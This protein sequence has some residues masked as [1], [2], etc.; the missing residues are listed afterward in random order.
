MA[1][2]NNFHTGDPHHGPSIPLQDLGTLDN[3]REGDT[4]RRSRSGHTNGSRTGRGARF[5]SLRGPTGGRYER[6]A[7]D[8]PSRWEHDG[9]DTVDLS[10]GGISV[11]PEG[12]DDYAIGPGLAH[13]TVGLSFDPDARRSSR[14]GPQEN[15]EGRWDV[16]EDLGTYSNSE[17]RPSNELERYCSP[18][19]TGENDRTP[20]TDQRYLQPI[21]GATAPEGRQSDQRSNQSV[22]FAN[23]VTAGSHLGDDL[24]HLEE[25]LGREGDGSQSDSGRS[26]LS[27]SA[28]IS[29]AGSVMRMISQRVVN[30]SNEPEM[31]EQPTRRKSSIRNARM[32]GPPSLPAMTEYAHDATERDK[33]EDEGTN[34]IPPLFSKNPPA[35]S[36]P[37]RGKSLG[38][39]SPENKL[40][41]ALCEILIHPVTEPLIFFLIILHTVLLAIESEF[42]Q[43]PGR[44]QWGSPWFDYA[45]LAL[46]II[47]TFELAAKIIVS[48]FIINP[49]EYSTLDRSRGLR[50]ALIDKGRSLFM[51]YRKKSIKKKNTKPE[52][53]SILRTFTGFPQEPDRA[54]DWA[55]QA[56]V[57][58]ARRAFLRHSFN[59]LDF[60]AVV[61]YWISFMLSI[62]HLESK[63]HLYVF[64]ML[65]CLR[66]LRLM[67]LTEGTLLILKGLKKAA[68]LLVNVAFF[69]CFFWLLFAIIGVQS[70]KSSLRRTCVWIDPD[71]VSNFT[72]NQAPD[73]LQL[74]GGYLES[75]T[76]VQK[77]WL[78]PDG[79]NGS[80]KPKGFLC[81]QG[82][83]CIE[84]V[85]PYSGTMSFDN[86]IQSLELVFVIMS[87][88]T[89]TDLLYY[90]TDSD[91]MA[92]ASFFIVGFV[93]LSLWLVNLLIAVITS[94]FQVIR[95]ERKTQSAFTSKKADRVG[96]E[97]TVLRKVS[98]LKR[99]YDK[100]YSFWLVII[101]FGLVVQ[102][103]RSSS[104]GPSRTKFI[105][106]TELAV[107]IIL[108]VEI[109]LR[110]FSDFR[111]FFR[112]AQNWVDL[113]LAITTTIIQLPPIKNSG[114][115][116]DAL[117][118]FQILRI[119][120]VVLS[121][122]LTRKLIMTVFR[123]VVGLLNLVFF[124]AIITLIT[125]IFAIQ[126]FRNQMPPEN[127]GEVTRVG[128]YNIWNAFIGM[129][130]VLSSENWTEILYSATESGT[131][132][133]TAWIAATF[134]I[135]WF[136][137]ANLIVLNMFIA[138]IQESF[139]V[140]EDEK[141]L[142]QVKAFLQQK[143]VSGSSQ[144][145]IALS[146][147]FRIGRDA[148]RYRDPLDHGPAA[149]EMLMKDA[150]V[151]EFL[152][153]Q[154]PDPT[155]HMRTT[156]SNLS[157]ASAGGS[158]PGMLANMLTQIKS[159][160][161][162]RE[163]NPFYSKIKI[164]RDHD[165]LDPTV[166]AKEVISAAEQRKRAQRQYLQ[167]YPNYNVSLFIFRPDHPLR[168]FCQRI[169]GPGRGNSR[170]E[171]VDPIK[172]VW[173]I[174][175]TFIYCAIVA[176]VFIACITTPLYQRT[177][178][179]QHDA[180]RRDWFV[181]TDLAFALIFTVEAAIKVIADGFFWT[182]NAYFR[183]SWGFID[184][185]V[186]ITLWINVA[187]S[188]Y[189]NGSVSRAVGAFKALRALRL[190]NVSNSARKTFHAVIIMGGWKVI[191]AAF[192]SMSFLIPFAIYGLNLF[193]NQMKSC[194]DDDFGYSELKHCVGEY[195]SSPFA[196]DVLAPRVVS[197][198]FY[199]FDTFGDSLFI[200]F[201]IVSQEGWTDAMWSAMSITGPG[202][203]PQAF[204]SQANALF[205]LVFNLLGAVFV[206]TLFVSVFMRN[207]TEQT[208]VAYLTAEQRSWLELRKLLRQINPSKRSVHK[209]NEKFKTFCYRIAV[210]KHG[211]WS[212]FVTAMLVLH[213]VLLVLEYY[214]EV[215]WWDRTRDFLFLALTIIFMANVIVRLVGLTWSR[216]RRSSW[217][218]YSVLSISGTFVTTLLS[219][220]GRENRTFEKLHKLFL[221]SI[222][223][224]LIPRNN[225]LDQLFKTA[226]ASFTAIANLLATWFVLFLVYA[227]AM[228]QI[229]GLTK[230]GE[231]ENGN[232][233]FR[234]VPKALV[235]LFRL[236]CGEG[237]N[238]VMEDFASMEYPYCTN[239]DDFYSSDCGSA[240]WARF[241][242]ISWNI[243]S[244]YIF[245][246]LF[247]SLVYE[248]FSYVYQR[249]SGLYAISREDIRRFKQAWA[250]FDPDGTGFISKE[251][252]P[253]LL[254][255]L[256][257]VFEMRI[258]D[259]EYTVG[260][261]LEDCRTSRRESGVPRAGNDYGVD[262]EMLARRLR[263][264]PVEEIRKRRARLNSFYEEMLVSAHPEKGISFTTCL[265]VLAHYTIITDSKSLRLEE[266]LRRRTRLQ[267]VEEAVRRN[268]VIGFF[269]TL[270]WSRR[271]RRRMESKSH[272]RLISVPQFSVPEIYVEDDEISEDEDHNRESHPG[273]ESAMLSPTSPQSPASSLR[274]T[275]SLPRLDTNISPQGSRRSSPTSREWSNISPGRSPVGSAS[276][277]DSRHHDGLA[278]GQ[279]ESHS[280]SFVR[281]VMD[282]LDNSAWGE[283]IRRSFTLRRPSGAGS[284]H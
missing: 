166:M 183:G 256:S 66:I 59:R 169:V 96:Q 25:G 113:F 283:S 106:D 22:R 32:D 235:L 71:G 48:G 55:Q 74:C 100:T 221:V 140:S 267:R 184:G 245:V 20:L 262:L 199:S 236:S 119:Y 127:N 141:R 148:Q 90:T 275:R 182:P 203:Q 162:N 260:S 198:D 116:Y 2:S 209:E 61:S 201:Q 251:V 111:K 6:V 219:L 75:G 72:F 40:R 56:R 250:T 128:F 163:P 213:L 176:M 27:S 24:P 252:F 218:L 167:K 47:Y 102:C 229:F 261:I 115:P 188:F 122:P 26:R 10:E 9:F 143:N 254:G 248:S 181:W 214:P 185:V 50:K 220:I 144:G 63:Y 174:F 43:K 73:Q 273:A 108:L 271:F 170:I 193:N 168:R 49:T 37:L 99:L 54:G 172:P 264:L 205:F 65:S 239:A 265:M 77:P 52:P 243:L 34:D 180:K 226:A 88:N 242:F 161:L 68:P 97:Q 147:V 124:V 202:K 195:K 62:F 87:S 3:T 5:G 206:L 135:M 8:S 64:R 84:G 258:Y 118:I 246:S 212:R 70:F 154:R 232:I 269:N 237:W 230:F 153:D 114:R 282:S 171:G 157:P 131:K 228:N 44:F 13:S 126:L 280:S 142:Q 51:P 224:L 15:I 150:V 240:V 244:M 227:I 86:I 30:L 223:L 57:R 281:E 187:A 274:S 91:Y 46:F 105:N 29:K 109:F 93:I 197:N 31:A 192:V 149:L 155:L 231:E 94:S 272:S 69:I 175:S 21:S 1:S 173:Y 60:V 159:R 186:L 189:Q 17:Y 18:P 95:E 80:D 279:E 67:A 139:D 138:V 145:N 216:F 123:N 125:A 76:G 132:W 165:D 204:A 104:M 107:T 133:N 255:E 257:G 266:F 211:R 129:Y 35:R 12:H 215:A 41:K 268:V 263:G 134:F 121:L 33:S 247:V 110:F 178:F 112:S 194:N 146:S 208:G 196:W 78:L 200:L 177:Y 16:S 7:D 234:T 207:Y 136:V 217:D 277:F 36:N 222:T 259:G 152:D 253:R 23:N 278:D 156:E 117:T 233:N 83:L 19:Q 89:F 276:W 11:P 158:G 241:L 39:F 103:M 179:Q 191:E 249:S 92:A 28:A 120:R 79:S 53:K 42:D 284:N 14:Y 210:K 270:Y 160:L 98:P 58:L 45:F 225:Q 4:T 164:S 85:N 130:Q 101:I 82:S 137:L 190:L 151:Q 38:V 238:A 81:P